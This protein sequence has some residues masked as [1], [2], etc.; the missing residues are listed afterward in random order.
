MSTTRN[1]CGHGVGR[2]FH[3]TPNIVHYTTIQNLGMM[4]PGHIFTIEVR[5]T[6]PPCQRACAGRRGAARRLSGLCAQ[7]MIQLGGHENTTLADGW[8]VVTSDGSRSAQFEHTILITEDGLCSPHTPPARAHTHPRGGT[9]SDRLGATFRA[10]LFVRRVR[11]AH[12][13]ARL[14]AATVLGARARV[15]R[16]PAPRVRPTRAQRAGVGP[17]QN[18]VF[19]AR[20]GG[21]RWLGR[22]V[23]VSRPWRYHG[24]GGVRARLTSG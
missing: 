16:A 10:R 17:V 23:Q 18:V 9:A 12:G 14:L 22:C 7:P 3:T 1:F 21:G 20:R 8:T 13:Q 2:V 6:L 15:R 11:A 19:L 24:G 4:A 5:P